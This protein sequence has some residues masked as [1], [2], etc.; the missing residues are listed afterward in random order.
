MSCALSL[1]LFASVLIAALARLMLS[2]QEYRRAL[3][4]YSQLLDSKIPKKP[5]GQALTQSQSR[6]HA[7]SSH[8]RGIREDV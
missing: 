1:T 8:M 2:L 3:S 4:G 6:M 5:E 7:W